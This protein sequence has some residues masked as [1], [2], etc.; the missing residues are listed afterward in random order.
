M[1]VE[2]AQAIAKVR[3]MFPDLTELVVPDAFFLAWFNWALSQNGTRFGNLRLEGVAFLLA[4][5]WYRYGLS[6]GSGIN[7]DVVSISTASI[8]ATFA[9]KSQIAGTDSELLSTFA[10]ASWYRLRNSRARIV[11]PSFF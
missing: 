8:S 2:P 11:L 7:G 1:T 10:G 6:K 4:H 9:Q 3:S 5:A